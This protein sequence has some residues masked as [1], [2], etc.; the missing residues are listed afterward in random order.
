MGMPSMAFK[1]LLWFDLLLNAYLDMRGAIDENNKIIK[2][3][4]YDA[5]DVTFDDIG[6]APQLLEAL[7]TQAKI[8]GAGILKTLSDM[9]TW[10]AIRGFEIQVCIDKRVY[11]KRQN[12]AVRNFVSSLKDSRGREN[13]TVLAR[14]VIDE[15][16]EC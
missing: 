5:R 11:N 3:V 7:R 9:L 4:Y 16:L 12:T 15:R 10:L 6:L 2:L 13:I 1:R 14:E 8:D